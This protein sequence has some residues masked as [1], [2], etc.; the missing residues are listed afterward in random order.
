MSSDR[1]GM[2]ESGYQRPDVAHV[3][4]FGTGNLA[5]L[6]EGI[7]NWG[8]PARYTQLSSLQWGKNKQKQQE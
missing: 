8:E 1:F 7:D 4:M 6:A 3:W 2:I 5:S